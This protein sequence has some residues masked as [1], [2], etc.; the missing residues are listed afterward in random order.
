MRTLALLAI[1]LFAFA[2]ARADQ[3][4]VNGGFE[5]GN[6][7]GWTVSSSAPGDGNFTVTSASTT[8]LTYNATVGPDSG[9]YYA[10]SDDY[11]PE[12]QYLTQVFT[13]GSSI[14]TA[15]LSFDMFVNDVYG[16]DFGS[17]G[18]GAEV[19]LL[20]STGVLISLLNGPVDTFE[21]TV[22]DPN[23]YIAYSDNLSALLAPNTTYQLQFSSTDTS[24]IIN[25]GIDNV[26]LLTSGAA[27]PIPEPATFFYVA[28]PGLLFFWLAYR[29]QN[30]LA[31]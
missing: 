18:P 28:L 14:G 24:A 8:P 26:S 27:S 25:T 21:S 12:T 2:S 19:S 23:P 17:S 15:T 29:K 30:S 1:I 31:A 3:L 5:D 11:G 4:I 20:S 10:V 9:T 7:T 22:G 16:S 13:T 6:L